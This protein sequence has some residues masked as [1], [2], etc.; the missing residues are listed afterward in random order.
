MSGF[1]LD[2]NVISEFARPDNNPDQ[3]VKQWLE[4]IDPDSL[5]ASVLT[6]GEIRRG[7]EKLPPGRRRTRLESWLMKDLHGWFANR[8]LIINGSIANRWGL[9][10]AAAQRSGRPLAVID[11]LLSA[12]ALEHNLTVV[13]RN[14]R[15]FSYAGVPILNPW[16]T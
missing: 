8:V 10:A 12:T 7:I 13:T 11:G 6:F 4:G 5:Y 2:T 1:L 14:T 9:L 16:Q 15:D 3:R